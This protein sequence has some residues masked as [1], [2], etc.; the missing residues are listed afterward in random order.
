MFCIIDQCFN[1][2]HPDLDSGPES[3]FEPG[4]KPKSESNLFTEKRKHFSGAGVVL[5]FNL[6]FRKVD[7]I[8]S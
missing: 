5:K 4:P 2:H 7:I 1:Y 3:E 8:A 6:I